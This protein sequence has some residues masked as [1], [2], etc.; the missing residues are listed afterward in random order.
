MP[1]IATDWPPS[2][3][4]RLYPK[5]RLQESQRLVLIPFC[6]ARARHASVSPSGVSPKEARATRPAGPR[7]VPH[8]RRRLPDLAAWPLGAQTLSDLLDRM[9]HLLRA[10]A[11]LFSPPRLYAPSHSLRRKRGRVRVGVARLGIDLPS[12]RTVA[13]VRQ[14]LSAVLAAATCGDIAPAEA[15]QYRRAGGRPAARP[16]AVRGRI[17]TSRRISLLIRCRLHKRSS[18][19]RLM[20]VYRAQERRRPLTAPLE[21]GRG[22]CYMSA[23]SLHRAWIMRIIGPV[24]V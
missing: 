8:P 10:L 18:F 21:F 23:M 20:V 5:P 12:L 1:E 15:A 24:L 13:N 16:G 4:N 19:T 6:L 9:P 14:V 11:P 7:G 3:S 2:S 17:A 22:R